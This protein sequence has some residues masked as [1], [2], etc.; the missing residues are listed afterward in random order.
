M[1][2]VSD[3][4]SGYGW[5]SIALHWLS[6]ALIVALWFIGHSI[7]QPGVDR[8]YVLNLHATIAATAW[9]LLA[10]RVIWRI[11]Q[12]HPGSPS[13]ERT[14]TFRLAVLVHYA[15]L[16]ALSVMLLTGPLILWFRGMGVPLF[17]ASWSSPLP[18]TPLL[19]E[20]VRQLHSWAAATL[21][22][23]VLLHIGGA[24]KALIFDRSGVFERMLV[25]IKAGDSS[26]AAKKGKR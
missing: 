24:L 17:G 9:L 11:R 6:A 19:A 20:S 5:I 3:A 1:W 21:C 16:A 15:I 10:A 12:R 14:V 26:S 18:A 7:S 25:A 2:R 23:G 4:P 22:I 8:A 13:G